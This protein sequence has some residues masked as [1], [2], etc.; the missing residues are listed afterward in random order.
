MP[1]LATLVAGL[2]AVPCVCNKQQLVKDYWHLA[3]AAIARVFPS[4]LINTGKECSDMPCHAM[5]CHAMLCY[6]M[7]C[8]AVHVPMTKYKPQEEQL[9]HCSIPVAV[10]NCPPF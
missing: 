1:R 7:P 4:H 3:N 10:T 2:S 5:P 8:H 6:A 9:I